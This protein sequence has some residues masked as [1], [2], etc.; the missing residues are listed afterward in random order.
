M[1]VIIFNITIWCFPFSQK[2][3][4]FEWKNSINQFSQSIFII[5]SDIVHFNIIRWYISTYQRIV[6][7]W[8]MP[9]LE[10]IVLRTHCLE[11]CLRMNICSPNCQ[12]YLHNRS[13]EMGNR[14]RQTENNFPL[15][16]EILL[17]SIWIEDL[18]SNQ[19]RIVKP[20]RCKA[21][22]T[23]RQEAWEA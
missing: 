12:Y 16:Y 4:R 20:H 15:N 21:S 13:L 2:D 17:L 22:R 1:I 3:A 9:D 8:K 19:K 5:L 14:G 11:A 7:K 23:S 18:G 10:S 6:L